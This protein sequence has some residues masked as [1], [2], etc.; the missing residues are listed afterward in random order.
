MLMSRYNR[1]RDETCL[2]LAGHAHA[3]MAASRPARA[4]CMRPV[5]PKATLPVVL[6]VYLI[7]MTTLGFEK[8]PDIEA[9]IPESE[10]PSD[11]HSYRH[12][13]SLSCMR[14]AYPHLLRVTG[15]LSDM[16]L[17]IV[18]VSLTPLSASK[19]SAFNLDCCTRFFQ[20]TGRQ[21]YLLRRKNSAITP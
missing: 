5:I 9:S 17:M 14:L 13:N 8:R 11:G 18:Y 2:V 21:R 15:P 1:Q 4:R 6:Y 7:I 16:S 20:D 19:P 10:P 3:R 12:S